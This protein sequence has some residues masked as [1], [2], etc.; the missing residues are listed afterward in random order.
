MIK[1]L[2]GLTVIT[3]VIFVAYM[4]AKGK[5]IQSPATKEI[6]VSQSETAKVDK[7][8]PK[9]LE[10]YC[11]EEV[12]KLPVAPFKYTRLDGDVH[13]YAIPDVSL[14]K[15]IPTDKFYKAKTCALWYKYDPKEAYASLGVEYGMNIKLDNAFEENADLVFSKAIDKSWQKISPLGKDERGRPGYSYPGFPLAFT[16]ENKDAGTTEFV[17]AD[18]GGNVFYVRFVAYEK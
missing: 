10:K 7:T 6:L 14:K 17:T 8:D 9:W 16:R 12:K 4:T 15:R 2:I 11:R 13:A 3:V 5:L 1:Y 18:F